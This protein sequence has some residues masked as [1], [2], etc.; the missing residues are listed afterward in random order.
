M[1]EGTTDG[2][3]GRLAPR[4]LRPSR[5][6]GADAL[7]GTVV[8]A[9]IF[10]DPILVFLQGLAPRSRFY[11]VIKIRFAHRLDPKLPLKLHPDLRAPG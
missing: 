5:E 9:D 3:D 4:N 1:P 8:A 2:A 10:F 7:I 11:P 6:N